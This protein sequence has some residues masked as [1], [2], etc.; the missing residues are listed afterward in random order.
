MGINFPMFL[1]LQGTWPHFQHEFID[2]IIPLNIRAK[3]LLA[4]RVLP[5][6][7]EPIIECYSVGQEGA[8]QAGMPPKPREQ[9]GTD[10]GLNMT[11]FAAACDTGRRF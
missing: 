6:W 10:V 3:F 1:D 11:Q 7:T 2:P 9:R 4:G 5:S 8:F